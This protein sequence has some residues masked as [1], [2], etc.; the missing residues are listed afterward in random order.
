[1]PFSHH[2]H[3]GQFCGHAKDNLSDVINTAR[4]KKMISFA[5]TEHMPRG[6]EDLYPEEKE[7]NMNSTKL[8]ETFEI[9]VK[10]ARAIQAESTAR[11]DHQTMRIL[12]GFE[13]DWIRPVECTKMIQDL[14]GRY[15]LDYFIGSVHHVKTIPIDYD[16]ELYLQ[17]RQ[18]CGGTE[19]AL[20]ETYYDAQ[21]DMLQALK[22]RVV[23][24][25]DLIRLLSYEPNLDWTLFDSVWQKIM[26]NLKFVVEYGG[27]LEINTSAWRKG[28]QD[29]YPTREICKA[30]MDL[31]GSF[32][33][34]DDSHGI[35]HVA[36][37]Y[38]KLLDFFADI[39]LTRISYLWED[40]G[41]IVVQSMIVEELAE[42]AF[43][44]TQE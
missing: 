6:D 44:K 29:P 21:Y 20:F 11:S 31:G 37:N 23:G 17:A 22:P 15:Q 26:R 40:G 10:E 42:L 38:H 39:E 24:H 32:V 19:E 25:F 41:S 5:L 4:K 35:D 33:T 2:S 18:S 7:A 14:M 13:A 3:S 36:T 9:Y 34:S 43:W 27:L 1:M 8:M 28:M 16:K 12:V 30:Y